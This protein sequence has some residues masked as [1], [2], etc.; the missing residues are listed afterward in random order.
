[1]VLYG[2]RREW[3]SAAPSRAER[4]LAQRSS[5]PTVMLQTGGQRSVRFRALRSSKRTSVH[6]AGIW[7]LRAVSFCGFGQAEY[8]IPK[9]SAHASP[10]LTWCSRAGSAATSC[11]QCSAPRRTLRLRPGSSGPSPLPPPPACAGHPNTP[12][13][14]T[15]ARI[16]NHQ[17]K[18]CRSPLF[19]SVEFESSIRFRIEILSD[20]TVCSWPQFLSSG[21]LADQTLTAGS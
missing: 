10:P 14:S 19:N 4:W 13:P 6:E 1:M 17:I 11:P 12:C 20:L 16:L 7:Q 8:A 21:K 5:A 15:P 9:V 2:P 3:T 18:P